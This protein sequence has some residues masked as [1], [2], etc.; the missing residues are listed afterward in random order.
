[1]DDDDL[2]FDFED[3]LAEQQAAHDAMRQ[4]AQQAHQQEL[5][6][7]HNHLPHHQQ[8]QQH[9]QHSHQQGG[10]LVPSGGAAAGAL[11]APAPGQGYQPRRHFR[12]VCVR[13]GLLD[14]TLC[15]SVLCFGC[16]TAG[17]SCLLYP[18]CL[19]LV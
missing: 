2:N 18:A 14:D 9:G 8:Q 11:G 10:A 7:H 13:L 1:M 19:T 16:G 3:N 15:K 6:T 17:V 4:Q 12:Q 5:M